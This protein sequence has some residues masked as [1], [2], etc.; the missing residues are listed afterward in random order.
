M[1]RGWFWAVLACAIAISAPRVARASTQSRS[2]FRLEI[3]EG[4]RTT[5]GSGI[6][7]TADGSRW[8]VTAYHNI[9]GKKCSQPS[10]MIAIVGEDENRLP[11][12]QLVDTGFCVFPELGVAAARVSA[13]GATLLEQSGAKAAVLGPAVSPGTVNAVVA[14]G[15]PELSVLKQSSQ[16]FDYIGAGNVGTRAAANTI[17]PPKALNAIAQ[18]TPLL[19]IDGFTITY[20]FSGGPVFASGNVDGT[21]LGMIQGGDPLN[22]NRSWAIPSDLIYAALHGTCA[23]SIA[24]PLAATQSWPP[25]G[26]LSSLYSR[27]DEALVDVLEVTPTPRVLEIGE[28]SQISIAFRWNGSKPPSLLIRPNL[29][30]LRWIQHTQGLSEDA[31]PATDLRIVANFE[32]V[33]KEGAP[34]HIVLPIEFVDADANRVLSTV[35]LPFTIEYPA[36]A[37]WDLSLGLEFLNSDPL[38]SLQLDYAP[39][40]P[41]A[42]KTWQ[43]ALRFG[44]GA[45]MLYRNR[46]VRDPVGRILDRASAKPFYGLRG[47]ALAELRCIERPL[48]GFRAD[49]G[50]VADYLAFSAVAGTADS[51]RHYRAGPTASVGGSIRA[52]SGGAI[53]LRIRGTYA[54]PPTLDSQYTGFSDVSAVA[55]Q[56]RPSAGLEL[57]YELE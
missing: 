34:A 35:E 49:L 52:I 22:K 21:V 9:H 45:D 43:F 2:T 19:F 54:A 41:F 20:G 32:L 47:L 31:R 7:L 28:K 39:V 38:T 50:F 11:I 13:N 44:V 48:F 29:D 36:P 27:E 57:S 25:D 17:L 14:V 10:C 23:P 8:L 42:D 30:R 56:Y 46:E 33:A 51:V 40:W 1:S 53:V 18:T 55:T 3:Q 16:P 37:V 24:V 26:F 5:V 4:A 12:A 6:Y 15:N